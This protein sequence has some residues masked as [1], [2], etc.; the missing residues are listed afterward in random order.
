MWSF[1][2]IF[3]IKLLDVLVISCSRQLPKPNWR[4]EQGSKHTDTLKSSLNLTN[5]CKSPHTQSTFSDD[6]A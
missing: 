1:E 2:F 3:F 4:Q 5:L 6:K